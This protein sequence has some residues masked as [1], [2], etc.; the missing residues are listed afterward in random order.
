LGKGRGENLSYTLKDFS[1]I[2]SHNTLLRKIVLKTVLAKLPTLSTY[3]THS[4]AVK[5]KII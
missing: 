5:E 1:K 4:T 2:F 3:V